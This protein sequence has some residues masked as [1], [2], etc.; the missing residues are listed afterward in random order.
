MATISDIPAGRSVLSTFAALG[1]AITDGLVAIGRAN[2]RCD[3]LERFV[4]M[5]DQ[6]LAKHGLTRDTIVR[7][8]YRDRIG[9]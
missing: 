4:N 6:E 5:S 1:V 9:L 7:H 3:E 2:A 8:V